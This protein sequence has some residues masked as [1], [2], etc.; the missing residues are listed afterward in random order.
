MTL[1]GKRLR[2]RVVHASMTTRLGVDTRVTDRL[3]QY[4]ANRAAGGVALMVTEPLSMARHQD[5]N[6]KIRAYDD[7]NVEGLKRLADAAESRDCRLLAQVQDPGRGRHTP[8]R[9]AD[10]IAP[11]AAPDDLSWGVARALTA[12]E[13]RNM[14]DEFAESSAR[15]K[16]CGFSGVEISCGHGHLFHQFLS[17][18]ANLRDDEYGGDR[19]GRTRFVAQIVDAI[20]CACGSDFIIGLKLPGDDGVPGSI[21]PAEAAAIALELLRGRTVEYLCFA[22]GSHARSLEM[23]VPDGH[24]PRATYMPLLNQLRQTLVSVPIVALGRITDPAEAEGILARGEAELIGLGRPLVTDPAWLNKAASDRAH[25]IRFCVSCNSCWGLNVSGVPI[26][27]DNNPR[28]ALPDEVDYRPAKAPKRRR[29]VVVGTGVAGLEAA[30]VAAERGHRVT[31][32]GR[33]GEVGGKVRLRS[34]LPGGDALSS[35]FDYQYAAAQRAGVKFELGV[36]AGIDDILRAGAETVILATGSTMVAPRWLPDEARAEGWVLDLRSAMAGL[37]AERSRQSGVAVVF[38]MD[39]TEGTYAAAQRLRE[40]FDETWIVTPRHSI[41][42]ETS[43]VTRQGILRRMSRERIRIAHLSEPRWTDRMESGALEIEQ[44]YTGER[45]VLEP[46]AF[47][48]YSTPRLPDQNLMPA[49]QAANI[50][51]RLI[52]DCV[53]ARNIMYAT[54]EGH[55]AGHAV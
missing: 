12:F 26:A 1:A 22:Q 33:S 39:H 37:V 35:I 32:F 54:A 36:E 19:V 50:E 24:S 46:I 23:H 7:A 30:W 9:V 18:W 34:L 14:V 47:L 17:P 3:V 2:N 5:V 25:D 42:D 40:I 31:V 44:V 13:I 29:V 43:L 11:T 8:G 4:Y 10:P 48:A 6:Y 51:T 21:D 38:D 49:L 27:C 45:T 16:H 41:A 55:A 52:G 53:M 15:V 20:R 28:V